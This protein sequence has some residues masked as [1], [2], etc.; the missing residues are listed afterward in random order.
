MEASTQEIIK[1]LKCSAS[2][3]PAPDEACRECRYG[4]VE[5]LDGEP[6]I[7]CDCDRI[8]MDAAERLGELSRG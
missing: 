2:T 3:T 5:D 1:A 4:I 6:Y 7:S 8:S